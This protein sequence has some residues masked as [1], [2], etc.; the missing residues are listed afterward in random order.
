MCMAISR[1][2]PNFINVYKSFV[3]CYL[4]SAPSRLYACRPRAGQQRRKAQAQPTHN[5]PFVAYYETNHRETNAK[6]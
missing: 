1:H 2:I 4:C 3:E 6:Q 5:P